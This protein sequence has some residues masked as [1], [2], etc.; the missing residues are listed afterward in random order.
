M[1][2][3]TAI[4]VRMAP[5]ILPNPIM[6]TMRQAS[7]PFWAAK[8]L[9]EMSRSEWE[10]LCDS[11]G[12]CCLYKLEDDETGE[13]YYTDV[14]CRYLDPD[15]CRCSDYTRRQTLVPDCLVLDIDHPGYIRMLPNSCAYRQLHEGEPL[16]D[17][18]P[19]ISGNPNSVHEAGISI[20]GKYVTDDEV[21]LD[22][23]EAH[24][25]GKLDENDGQ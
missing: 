23:L 12:R 9:E 18:H 1:T 10:S 22:E 3:T 21:N 14:A 15:S 6:E 13:I 16:A 25:I 5:P 2:Q 24:I 8:K 17:W 19:L 7:P 20:K 4:R 11:C